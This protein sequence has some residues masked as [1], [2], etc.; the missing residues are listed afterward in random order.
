VVTLHY[1]DNVL[2]NCTVLFQLSAHPSLRSSKFFADCLRDIFSFNLRLWYLVA[3]KCWNIQSWL[4]VDVVFH[5]VEFNDWNRHRGP[6]NTNME[7]KIKRAR[8]SVIALTSLTSQ[9]I[10]V[11]PTLAA[12]QTKQAMVTH[13]CTVPVTRRCRHQLI[14]QL[15]TLWPTCCSDCSTGPRYINHILHMA[16]RRCGTH[17]LFM[18]KF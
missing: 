15:P 12:G 8:C 1:V 2:F 10:R 4:K 16:G 18:S 11:C 3:V 6:W 13:I 5:D 9:L 17:D 7:Q 14:T